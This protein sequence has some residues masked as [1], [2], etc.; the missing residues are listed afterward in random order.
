MQADYKTIKLARFNQGLTQ[1]EL[2]KKANLF[3]TTISKAE[4]GG[5]ITPKSNRA[6]RDALG[7]K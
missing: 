2:A 5:S 3:V 4:N 1:E 7:L 6:I